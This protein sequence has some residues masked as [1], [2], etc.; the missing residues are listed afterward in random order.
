MRLASWKIC[1]NAFATGAHPGCWTPLCKFFG[2]EE[3][4]KVESTG[5]KKEGERK[6]RDGLVWLG[7]GGAIAF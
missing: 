2:E 5:E 6:V 7:G 4:E 3:K 1:K